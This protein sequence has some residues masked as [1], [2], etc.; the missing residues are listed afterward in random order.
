MSKPKIINIGKLNK[1]I[2]IDGNIRL[3]NKIDTNNKEN[4][5]VSFLGDD[6]I[7]KSTMMNCFI[8]FLLNKNTKIFNKKELYRP[9]IYMVSLETLNEN[10]VLLYVNEPIYDHKL[11]LFVFI[12]SN[13]IIY[14]ERDVIKNNVLESFKSLTNIMTHIEDN[15]IKRTLLFRPIDINLR[16]EYDPFKNINE[17]LSIKIDDQYSNI[18]KSILKL[19]SDIKCKPTYELEP[20]TYRKQE[21]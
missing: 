3:E 19:F 1:F 10:I 12:I 21:D 14:N 16:D 5:I 13:L 6:N 7:G 11:R 15:H 9:N 8:S 17:L 18:R 4:K 2:T 20:F